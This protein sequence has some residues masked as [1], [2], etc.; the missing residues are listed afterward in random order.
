MEITWESLKFDCAPLWNPD[1]HCYDDWESTE[2]PITVTNTTKNGAPIR[3]T[4]TFIPMD[5]MGA[6]ASF[7][8]CEDD[9]HPDDFTFSEGQVTFLLPRDTDGEAQATVNLFLTGDPMSRETQQYSQIGSIKTEIAPLHEGTENLEP[10]P[11]GVSDIQPPPASD[12]PLPKPA[13]PLVTRPAEKPTG[14]AQP[15]PTAPVRPEPPAESEQLP[16]PTAEGLPPETVKPEQESTPDAKPPPEQNS[17][18][19]TQTAPHTKS[20]ASP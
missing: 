16:P 12:L 4:L 7:A 13:P 18:E 6:T 1:E 14:P 2:N 10:V 11:P 8:P 20:G 15:P 19:E 17:K 9:P 3:V 5:K